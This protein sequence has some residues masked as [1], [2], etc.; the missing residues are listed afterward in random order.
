M[1]VMS[2]VFLVWWEQRYKTMSFAMDKTGSLAEEEEHA[3][4]MVRHQRSPP[5]P[6]TTYIP[7]IINRSYSCVTPTYH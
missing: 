6:I 2:M 4:E 1:L 3:D 7:S 5:P